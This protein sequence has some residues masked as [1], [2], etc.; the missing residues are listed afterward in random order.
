[1]NDT[2]FYFI[3]K[4]QIHLGQC[5][6]NSQKNFKSSRGTIKLFAA[7]QCVAAHRLPDTDLGNF[8]FDIFCHKRF[9]R[10]Q[11]QALPNSV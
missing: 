3:L 9:L 2:M 4:L 7:P 11:I 10:K 8:L 6:A 5:L 1:M